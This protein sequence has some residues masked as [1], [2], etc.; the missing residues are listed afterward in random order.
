M[1]PEKS[2]ES[3]CGV[4]FKVVVVRL[5]DLKTLVLPHQTTL[6]AQIDEAVDPDTIKRRLEAKEADPHEYTKYFIDMM[7]SL[8]AQ[9]RDEDIAKLRT[10]TDP[11]ECFR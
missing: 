1:K 11:S 4:S 2:V 8:C 7:A 6:K 3:V 5:Q 9:C 10:T